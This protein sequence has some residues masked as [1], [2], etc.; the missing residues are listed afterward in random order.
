MAEEGAFEKARAQGTY[1]PG[2]HTAAFA[3]DREPT[4]RGGAADRE[5]LLEFLRSL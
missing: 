3:P 1:P 2:L 4:I 5:A